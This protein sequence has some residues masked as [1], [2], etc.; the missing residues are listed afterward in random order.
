MSSFVRD[1]APN[2]WLY[3]SVVVLGAAVILTLFQGLATA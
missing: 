1:D 2:C 3:T